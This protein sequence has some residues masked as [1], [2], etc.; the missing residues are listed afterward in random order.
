MRR[1]IATL[2]GSTSRLA[3]LNAAA[4]QAPSNVLRDGAC[5]EVVFRVLAE[6]R[7]A[8][9]EPGPQLRIG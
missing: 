9:V 2:A 5:D 6:K 4:K 1:A 3:C 8:S 7:H